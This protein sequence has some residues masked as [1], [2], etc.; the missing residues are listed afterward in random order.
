MHTTKLSAFCSKVLEIGWLLAVVITPL[1]FNVWSDRVFEPDKLT[2][3]RSLATMMAVI[4][5]VKWLD[6]SLH[7]RRAVGVTWRTPL[8]LP[9]LAT[10]AA[11]LISTLFSVIPRVSLWGSYQRLQGTYTTLSYIVIFFVILQEMRTRIQLDRLIT[12]IILNSLP[13]ALY[14]FLQR[15]NLDPLPWG[16]DV[17]QRIASN[18]GNAIFVAA[19]LI[20]AALPTLARIVETFRS[21][22][23][24]EENSTAD[25][26]RASVYIFTFLVQIIAIWYTLSRGPQMGLLIGLGIFLF[27][28]LLALQRAERQAQPAG[29]FHL[30]RDLGL[31]TAFGLG[32]LAAASAAAALAYLVAKFAGATASALPWIALGAGC[33]S[34]LGIWL[35]FVAN[36][37]GWRW[38]WMS[39]L[40]IILL[41][42]TGFLTINLVEP[43]H[44]WSQQQPWLGR[45]DEVLQSESGTGK[46]RALLWQQ[47]LDLY[48]PHEPIEYPPTLSNPEWRPDRLNVIRPLIGYGPESMF[49][50]GSRFYPLDLA[51]YEKRTSSG[52]RAHNE[53]MDTLTFTGLLGFTAYVWL[54]GSIFYYGLRWLGFLPADWRRNVF[55]ILTA[56]G[57]AASAVAV[58]FL[59]GP[60]FFGLAVPVGAVGGLFLYLTVYGF[61]LYGEREET[62]AEPRPTYSIMLAG[63]LAAIVAHLIEIN[64]GIAIASTRTTF[65]AY[66]GALVVGGLRLTEEARTEADQQGESQE[67]KKQARKRRRVRRHPS[68]YPQ[69][70]QWL[71]ETMSA[72]VV[73]G[74]MLGTLAFDF[75]GTNPS[76][77]S[78]PLQIIWQ[79]L[80]TLYYQDQ[81]TS[82]GILVIVF[83]LLW[84]MGAV[85]FTS[86][87]AKNK[88]FRAYGEA[89]TAG[90]VYL[91]TSL[92]VGFGFALALAS[93]LV[94]IQNISSQNVIPV[95]PEV[96][97]KAIA[98][99]LNLYYYLILFVLL[100][101]GAALYFDARQRP[102]ALGHWISIPAFFVLAIL[103]G[104]MIVHVNLYP[105]HA[106]IIYKQGSYARQNGLWQEA[107]TY[108][109]LV[110]QLDPAQ[111]QYYLY[112]AMD[113]QQYTWTLNDPLL[114]NQALTALTETALKAQDLNPLATDHSVNLAR[115]YQTWWQRETDPASRQTLAER[116]SYYYQIATRLSPNSALIWD[117]WA[118]FLILSGDYAAAQEKLDH[119]LQLDP[120][121]DETWIIQASLYASQGK[122]T[123]AAEAYEQALAL[124]PNRTDIR[125]MMGDIYYDQGRFV[126]AAQAYEEALNADPNYVDAWLRLGD[127]YQSQGRMADAIAA[128]EQAA[129]LNPSQPRLWRVLGFLYAQ[130]SRPL[131]AVQALQRSIDLSPDSPENWE[132]HKWMAIAYDQLGQTDQAL[133][134]AQK[135]L[136]LAPPESQAE[137]QAMVDQLSATLQSPE[138][139]P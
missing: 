7:H 8:I 137:L 67:A 1:F 103:A 21:I 18:M 126:E 125:L 89:L 119:S 13:I 48:L 115:V 35:I 22:L 83:G 5:L 30:L 136:A 12:V 135:A 50:A 38:L 26:L 121:F 47:A 100:V 10:I 130:S 73:G 124:S 134:Q 80:T 14:G 91:A 98:S 87:M 79:A 9:T 113:L 118:Q 41:A 60:H 11:Y 42:S 33:L 66:A 133:E 58:G 99:H 17:S 93:H 75:T 61:S 105:I 85:V 82:Y 129:V 59:I 90:G 128:Y 69:Q 81:R 6:E 123:E 139:S 55:F 68:T 112:A 40:L 57:A 92:I 101:G 120:L 102:K 107:L 16:G 46:V 122:M 111:D 44:Q 77:S 43:V 4:W 86:Q 51:H 62:L 72:G 23:S 52:D 2:V 71:W 138:E 108:D 110:T 25:V 114:L 106:D 24:D 65:W 64:F 56:G 104:I 34:L 28:G 94:I 95:T 54:F 20:M 116:V 45:L 109:A 127:A 117:N 36:R 84:V 32:S 15:N 78:N 37:W 19:Y 70:A 131:E 63:I 3:L 53:T 76:R 49:F 31:G 132:A 39:A 88:R 27:L 29:S 96:I 97:A 74:F